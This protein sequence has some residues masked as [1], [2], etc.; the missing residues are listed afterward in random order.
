M[1]PAAWPE[2]YLRHWGEIYIANPRIRE[3]GVSLAQFL[4][5]P[6]RILRAVIFAEPEH[7]PLLRA[8][9][10]VQ[11]RLDAEAR[12]LERLLA[13]RRM[14]VSDGACVEVMHHRCWPR[15][16]RRR[17]EGDMRS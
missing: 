15:H 4:E 8:Q 17:P 13:S 5:D 2:Y 11:S 16:A 10:D 7:Q 6:E 12:A 9:R 3:Y 14:R 1:M